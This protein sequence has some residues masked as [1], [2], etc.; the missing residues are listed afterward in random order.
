MAAVADAGGVHLRGVRRA[1]PVPLADRPDRLAHEHGGVGGV[2]RGLGRHG[3]LELPGGVLGVVL[4]D[5]DPLGREG[6]DHLAR[7]VGRRAEPGQP[8]G[9]AADGGGE[10]VAVT[11]GDHPLDLERAP[12]REPPF[13]V[14][15]DQ[16]AQQQPAVLVVRVATLREALARRPG[17]ARLCGEHHEPFEVGHDPLVAHRPLTRRRR[18]DPVVEAEVVERGGEPHAPRR[19]RRKPVEGHGLGPRDPGVV[20]EAR[21]DRHHTTLREAGHQGLGSSR[22][23]FACGEIHLSSSGTR[24]RRGSRS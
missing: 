7:V 21:R 3:E 12:E 14:L 9:R 10:R 5:R 6:G 8:V 17:P 1:E 23:F 20:H 18:R 16:S 19:E 24:G 4:L 2:H 11:G 22:A 13:G 15:V